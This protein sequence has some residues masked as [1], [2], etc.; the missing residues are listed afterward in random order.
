MTS[1]SQH[2]PQTDGND[3]RQ[4]RD[5]QSQ[6]RRFADIRQKADI[7]LELPYPAGLGAH[8]IP[9]SQPFHGLYVTNDMIARHLGHFRR[10]EIP[11]SQNDLQRT[12]LH[13]RAQCAIDLVMQGRI[14]LLEGD[15]VTGLAYGGA[16]NLQIVGD[17]GII[18]RD[19]TIE[20]ERVESAIAQIGK[21]VGLLP[22][23]RT[24]MLDSR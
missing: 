20:Q 2:Q 17:T 4:R 12:V 15:A 24:V 21:R 14:T 19:R 22:Y 7:A 11:T 10:P 6:Q 3:H 5:H 16:D 23:E 9:I 8:R 18:Q 13:H 1:Q